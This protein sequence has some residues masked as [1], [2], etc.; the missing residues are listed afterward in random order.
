MAKTP[1]ALHR[2]I[3]RDATG[4]RDSRT[5]LDFQATGD[6]R[7]FAMATD[8]QADTYRGDPRFLVQEPGAPLT[9]PALEAPEETAALPEEA[10]GP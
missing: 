4:Y 9:P 3:I 5:G 7:A 1:V 8:Q 6:G 2:V 10:D